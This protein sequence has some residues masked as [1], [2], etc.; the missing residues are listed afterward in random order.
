MLYARDV[1]Q[2]E[3]SIG[4]IEGIRVIIAVVDCNL[5]RQDNLECVKELMAYQENAR[6][7]QP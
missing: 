6:S 2:E 4:F 5:N 3:R 7:Q 1:G